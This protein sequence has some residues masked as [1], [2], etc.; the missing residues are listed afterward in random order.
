MWA[1]LGWVALGAFLG[2]FVVLVAV[3]LLY[4]WLVRDFDG[5]PWTFR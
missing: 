3:I 2:G 1:V 4:R 5:S